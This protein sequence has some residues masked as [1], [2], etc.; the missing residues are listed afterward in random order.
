MN[1]KNCRE[2][3]LYWYISTPRKLVPAVLLALCLCG[4]D[5]RITQAEFMK[6]LQEMP[7]A[8]TTQPVAP[9]NAAAIDKRLGPYKVGPSDVLTVTVTPADLTAAVPP[10]RVRVSSGGTVELPMA[11]KVT[12]GDMTLEEAEE[13]VQQAYVPKYHR[14]ASVHV[15]VVE[16]APTRVL[17]VGAVASP[18]LQALR[19][20]E[21]NLLFAMA[22]AGGAS[23]SAS[24]VVTLRRLRASRSNA[25]LN[26]RN[27]AE[28]RDALE[29]DPLEDGDIVVVHASKPNTVFVGGLVT[30]SGPQTYPP[31]SEITILQAIAAAGGLRTDLIPREGTL[32]RRLNGR[33]VHVRLDMNRL[34]TGKDQNLALA[35][36]DILWVPHTI[37]TRIHDFINNTVYVRTGA[38][39][40]YSASYTDIGSKRYGDLK[41][42]DTDTTFIGGSN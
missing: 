15:E 19:R 33:D 37:D 2:R 16:A 41:D 12:V 27:P 1:G 29:L 23:E 28:L 11:G 26:L 39:A 31:G 18:G 21:R 24:G 34:A 30:A 22:V 42:S 40:T 5:H 32:I 13:A 17:V 36:G 9:S 3:G 8:P 38:S 35:A 10:V 14:Q 20:T 6:M 4:C 25:M 7:P